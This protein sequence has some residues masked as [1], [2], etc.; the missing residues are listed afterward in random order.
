M[1]MTATIPMAIFAN[2][3]ML[4]LYRTPDRDST[5]LVFEPVSSELGT[6]VLQGLIELAGHKDAQEVGKV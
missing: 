1:P 3:D 5:V 2:I 6:P 4:L